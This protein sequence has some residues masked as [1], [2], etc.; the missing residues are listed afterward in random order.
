MTIQASQLAAPHKESPVDDVTPE[1]LARLRRADDAAYD[2]LVELLGGRLYAVA[3]RMLGRTEEAQDAVQE[4]F[5]N[6]FRS[7]ERF[8]GRSSLSTWLH[9]I[10]MNACLMRLR[11]RRR[12][13]EQ[14]MDDLLPRFLPDGHQTIPSEPWRP[15]DRSGI[16][17]AEMRQLVRSKIDEL[18]EQFREI[19]LL[20]DVEEL[21]TEQTAELLGVTISVVKTR[22]HRARQA[23][24]SMLDPHFA[25]AS[26]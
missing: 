21:D 25:E 2:E 14:Q 1:L 12:R 4:G 23:L 18:P 26:A 20:R 9:R 6:A 5:L 17:H 8:D 7:L 22:L 13:P 16:E 15:I 10:V 24:R 3:L 11:T 19:L